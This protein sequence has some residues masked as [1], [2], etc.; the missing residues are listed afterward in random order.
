V[1]NCADADRAR[2]ALH[3]G[4]AAHI[5]IPRRKI[6]LLGLPSGTQQP[7]VDSVVDLEITPDITKPQVS[8]GADLRFWCTPPGT[9]TPNPLV[10]SWPG[11][12]PGGAG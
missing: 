4:D 3:T 11:G 1:E 10:K 9:R 7:E 6:N 5:K 12:L 8:T 2:P